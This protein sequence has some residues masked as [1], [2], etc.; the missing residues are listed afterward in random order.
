MNLSE[1]S[2]NNQPPIP[3]PKVSVKFHHYTSSLNNYPNG[4]H[5]IE[6]VGDARSQS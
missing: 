1:C 3:R 4:K 6:S 2:K 5:V